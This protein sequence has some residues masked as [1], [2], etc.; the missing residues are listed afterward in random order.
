M[1]ARILI[2]GA[3]DVGIRLGKA[4][5][6][7]GH[8]VFALRRNTAALPKELHAV[9]AD[10]NDP[11]Q[12]GGLPAALTHVAYTAAADERSDAAYE[13]AY[14]RGLSNLLSA[15]AGQTTLRRAVFISSTAVY[16]QDD[17][18]WVTEE[19]ATEPQSFAGKRTLEAEA[20]LSHTNLEY[21]ILRCGG[22]YGEGRTRL[23]DQ[24]L[25]G[26]ASYDPTKTEYTNRIH[27]DDVARA[28]TLLL[29]HPDAGGLYNGVDTEPAPR[30]EVLQWLAQELG[31]PAPRATAGRPTER[32]PGSKRV[33]SARLQGLGYEFSY[34]TY[35]EGYRALITLSRSSAR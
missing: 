32:G 18:S 29:L 8:E 6:A 21:A 27:S 34:P 11:A 16:A 13:R 31:A 22:I 10:L 4:L 24:V 3:G 15:L 25:A 2:A 23:L 1:S 35:R 14:V 12:L 30:R 20:Q 33:S 7:Q 17:D 28:L 9:G 5:V 26:N 19:S